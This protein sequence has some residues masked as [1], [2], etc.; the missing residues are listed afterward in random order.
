[1]EKYYENYTDEKK[2]TAIIVAVD[3]NSISDFDYSLSEMKRLVEACDMVVKDVVVQVLP[4]PNPGT[5]VG[6]GKLQ[7][8]KILAEAL[9]IDYC[10][11]AENLSPAQLKNITDEV[12]VAVL[13][14]T[15]LILEI[16]AR[17][18]KTRE[19]RLQVESANL[20]YL[21]PRLVGMRK[22]LGRQAGASGSLSNKGQGEKQLEL[23]RR[24][25]ERRITEVRRELDSIN[26]DRDVQRA[27][28]QKNQM[29]CVAMVGYTNAGKSTLMNRLLANQ[30][31]E[32]DK[33]V[34][35][36]DM[37]FATLDT[38]IRRIDCS[39]NKSFLLSDTVGFVSNLPHGLVKAFR[40]TLSEACLADLLL[41][42]VDSADPY[43]KEQLDV[44]ET[45]LKELGCSDIDRIYVYNK[46]DR[47]EIVPSITPYDETRVYIS[48]KNG[49][50]IENLLDEIKKALYK[51][52]RLVEITIP[53]RDGGILDLLNREATVL[54]T[55]YREDGIF[56]KADVSR[57][58]LGMLDAKG[59]IR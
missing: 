47:L 20:Q 44:T 10:I 2:L 5:Y 19:A 15:G 38:T 43:V 9:E 49:Y 46:C 48:A 33:K 28:R 34:F 40:T 58:I 1:M 6:S 36:K 55:D 27:L 50:G 8:I 25:I 12:D 56:V 32:D 11:V 24:H 35:E 4:N 53:Y 42:V 37:L 59:L 21:L 52:N 17:R 57:K 54:E 22:S 16:F 30:N 29:P 3:D 26:H 51:N 14:R 7:E 23:D 41:I 45:T 31:A 13:D 39:D 18:A